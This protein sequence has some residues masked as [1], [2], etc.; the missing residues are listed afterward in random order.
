MARLFRRQTE[1]EYMT[2]LGARGWRQSPLERWLRRIKRVL[3]AALVVAVTAVIVAALHPQPAKPAPPIGVVTTAAAPSP[4]AAAPATTGYDP[5]PAGPPATDA[6]GQWIPEP[7]PSTSTSQ[8][9][10]GGR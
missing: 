7:A 4:H 1:D 5:T 3:L 6:Q 8:G 2:A 10:G 9:A